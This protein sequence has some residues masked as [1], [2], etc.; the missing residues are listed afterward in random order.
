MDSITLTKIL[1]NIQTSRIDKEQRDSVLFHKAMDFEQ[2]LLNNPILFNDLTID[3]KTT[4]LMFLI[5]NEDF[6][7]FLEPVF[8]ESLN[9]YCNDMLKEESEESEFKKCLSNLVDVIFK[10]NKDDPAIA[11][12]W[13]FKMIKKI[14]TNKQNSVC[15]R[16]LFAISGLINLDD[17]NIKRV[18]IDLD[19]DSELKTRLLS[20][21]AFAS[22]TKNTISELM[23]LGFLKSMP[24]Y[25]ESCSLDQ[26]VELS[27][28][29]P[30]ILSDKSIKDLFINKLNEVKTDLPDIAAYQGL[31]KLFNSLVFARPSVLLIFKDLMKECNFP[32]EIFTEEYFQKNNSEFKSDLASELSILTIDPSMTN[33]CLEMG[34]PFNCFMNM[35]LRGVE[36]K[37]KRDAVFSALDLNKNA[38]QKDIL[39]SLKEAKSS[40]SMIEF[41]IP[42]NLLYKL[43]A[44]FPEKRVYNI[45]FGRK[46]KDEDL[47]FFAHYL[48]LSENDLN[49]SDDSYEIL[50]FNFKR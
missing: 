42:Q 34:V 11:V 5:R 46:T 2:L 30:A 27:S 49:L 40:F 33:L 6:K 18:S 1:K 4:L 3:L 10:I 28:K 22:T 17:Y 36:S 50:I 29:Y 7:I 45:P 23:I 16:K 15:L 43:M 37:F 8:R 41:D 25:F 47:D 38:E 24:E 39:L 44:D 48:E 19:L 31:S 12:N 35:D 13:L 32:K 21:F 9:T 26:K 20:V 14:E